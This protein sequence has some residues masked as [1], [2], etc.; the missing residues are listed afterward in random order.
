MAKQFNT[1]VRNVFGTEYV[2]VFCLNSSHLDKV[3]CFLSLDS[4]W[5]KKVNNSSGKDLTIYPTNFYSAVEVKAHI[6]KTLEYFFNHLSTFEN[7]SFDIT[8]LKNVCA[9]S[10]DLYGSGIVKIQDVKKLRNGL[11]DIRLA[12][13]F[14]LKKLLKN[15]TPLEKQS[16][17]LKEW[18]KQKG[19][20]VQIRKMIVDYVFQWS[21]YQNENV[22]HDY[23]CKEDEIPILIE[24][25]NIIIKQLLEYDK[26]A[27]N[28]TNNIDTVLFMS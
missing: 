15:D 24:F 14:F 22:K 21:K 25:S 8:E 6:D 16:N 28:A 2:K 27:N 17:N 9:K 26:I 12:I 13:E 7:T 5:I 1:E 18:L 19:A 11:D 3:R 10:Y 20:S 23:R 4:S